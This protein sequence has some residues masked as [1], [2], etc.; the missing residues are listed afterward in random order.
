M[1]P[2]INMVSETLSWNIRQGQVWVVVLN[3][4][5]CNAVVLIS[6]VKSFIVQAH[7]VIGTGLYWMKEG[8]A[9]MGRMH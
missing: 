4:P 2:H 5:A 1:A 9:M 8:L 6:F 3:A 7:D